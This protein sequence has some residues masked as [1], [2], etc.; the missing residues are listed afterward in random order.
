[1]NELPLGLECGIT[2]LQNVQEL[3]VAKRKLLRNI[4]LFAKP[5]D[6][7]KLLLVTQGPVS[8][9][10]GPWQLGKPALE[11]LAGQIPDSLIQ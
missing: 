4:P 3:P 9:V 6:F 7:I 5:E 2:R 10:I 11:R 1:M 8:N